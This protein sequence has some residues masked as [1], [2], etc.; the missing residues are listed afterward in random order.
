MDGWWV[1]LGVALVV[2]RLGF[3]LLHMSLSGELWLAALLAAAP[4]PPA[5]Q[6]AFLTATCTAPARSS[7]R[8]CSTPPAQVPLIANTLP[9]AVVPQLLTAMGELIP[10]TPHSEYMLRLAV[11]CCD[12]LRC[13]CAL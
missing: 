11:L 5:T 6:C 3:C 4:L 1:A 13:Y 7:S 2:P 12:M 9:A 8:P 10:Q